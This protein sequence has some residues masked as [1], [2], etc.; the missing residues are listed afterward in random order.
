MIA[1]AAPREVFKMTR[2]TVWSPNK[3]FWACVLATFYLYQPLI[4]CLCVWGF[5]VQHHMIWVHSWRE[6]RSALRLLRVKQ[7]L[8]ISK[9]QALLESITQWLKSQQQRPWSFDKHYISCFIYLM[10]FII[11]YYLIDY[12][13][14][15]A[16]SVFLSSTGTIWTALMWWW[17]KN[18]FVIP[19]FL[20]NS[21]GTSVAMNNN[22]TDD[23]N[24][25]EMILCLTDTYYWRWSQRFPLSVLV[26][27]ELNQ[28]VR[29]SDLL[30]MG[31][32]FRHKKVSITRSFGNLKFCVIFL[33]IPGYFL[34]ISTY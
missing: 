2:L 6:P 11:V 7:P 28:P 30:P 25:Q 9:R 34:E 8:K 29:E 17:K 4:E 19:Y 26:S 12:F 31:A 10:F 27:S 32:R 24:M 21:F 18:T 13:F 20:F 14:C 5:S 16:Y 23:D 22:I 1:N 15:S 3:V 33:E